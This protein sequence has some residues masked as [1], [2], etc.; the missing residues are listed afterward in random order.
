MRKKDLCNH[1]R[2]K[3]LEHG[4]E[5]THAQSGYVVDVFG[6]AAR[7]ELRRHKK[8]VMPGVARLKLKR[9]PARKGRNPATG[10]TIKIPAKTVIKAT[11]TAALREEFGTDD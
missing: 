7:Q 4:L 11:A 2:A 5:L 10:E 9:Q 8:F 1:V 3:L 6:E